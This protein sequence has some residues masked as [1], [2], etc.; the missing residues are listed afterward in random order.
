[1]VARGGADGDDCVVQA[2][3]GLD[4]APAGARGLMKFVATPIDGAY[5]VE[6]TPRADDRGFFARVWCHEEFAA[7][8]LNAA[9]VQCNESL[10]RYRGTLRGLHYQVAPYG[11][12]K[13]IRCVRGAVFD[14]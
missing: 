7:H 6:P 13:L 14:V 11:E 9:F 4:L 8:G 3:P 10:S 2:L 5:L 1:M 12:A